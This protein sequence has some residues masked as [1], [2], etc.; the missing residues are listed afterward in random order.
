MFT[1]N[2]K[3]CLMAIILDNDKIIL[4]DIKLNRRIEHHNQ[5]KLNLDSLQLLF[6]HLGA[7]WSGHTDN[8]RLEFQIQQIMDFSQMTCSIENH[9]Q[10]LSVT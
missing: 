4:H 3:D 8:Q 1:L 6:I 5:M 9:H 2:E 10:Q 7:L